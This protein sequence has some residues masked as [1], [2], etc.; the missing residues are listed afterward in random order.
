MKTFSK[1]LPVLAGAIGAFCA[2]G[3]TAARANILFVITDDHAVQ[4]FGTSS[5][6]SPVPFP[7]FRRL[8]DEGMVFDRS[9]CANSLCGPSRATIYTARHSHMNAYLYNGGPAFDGSQPTWAKMLQSAGYQTALFGKWH[10]DSMPTGFDKWEVFHNQG[11]YYNP[12]YFDAP[13]GTWRRTRVHGYSTDITTQKALAWLDARDKE[14]PFAM[15][16][17]HKAPHRP[18]L[19]AERHLG[20]A[21]E[22]VAKLPVPETFFDDY[23]NR[24]ASMEFNEQTIARHF[25][26]W[27]DSHVLPPEFF[28]NPDNKSLLVEALGTDDFA[29]YIADAEVCA[30]IELAGYL[31]RLGELNR[32]DRAQKLAWVRYHARR[33]RELVQ[34]VKNGSIATARDLAVWRWR[35]YMEDYL[36][37]LLAVDESL[38][39]V[40]DYLDA[41]GLSENTLLVYCGD[42]GFYTGSH[43]M[44]DKRWIFEESFRMPLAMRWKG[45]IKPGVR[46]NAMVQNIDY[47]PTF[48]HI[49]GIDAKSKEGGM[50]GLDMSG[51]FATGSDP[52]FDDR[53]LYYAFYENPGEHNAPRHDGIRTRRWTFARFAKNKYWPANR[54]F[55]FSDEWLLIDNENDPMQM[56]NLA[57]D[58]A[59][60]NVFEEMKHR[61]EKQRETYQVPEFLPGGDLSNVKPRW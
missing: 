56:K 53:A 8:A 11:E 20:K 40:L 55:S 38:G 10:L 19:P 14:R 5:N 3:Q 26:V 41:N 39:K 1:I 60:A 22:Y 43:G 7:N 48:C 27:S 25:A 29:D 50:Q 17:A 2:Y 15:V 49:A 46:S 52:A 13:G 32:M 31:W 23:K 44:Y 35:T 21:R 33:T 51:L 58:P 36:G 28:T 9:Y 47:G 4:A 54:P 37:T 6:D 30:K 57:A 16:L 59:F 24:P 61:Y 12:D 34:S 42:Q 45:H 18:W